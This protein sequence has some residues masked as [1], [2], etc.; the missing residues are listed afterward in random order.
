MRVRIGVVVHI[1]VYG[2]AM[3]ILMHEVTKNAV[4]I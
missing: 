1:A 3:H 2:V 4:L